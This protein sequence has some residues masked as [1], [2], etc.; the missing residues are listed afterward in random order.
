[1]LKRLLSR[2]HD[3][4]GSAVATAVVVLAITAGLGTA[5]YASMTTQQNESRVE[6]VRESSFNLAEGALNNQIFALTRQ[7]PGKGAGNTPPST[8]YYAPCTQGS[9]GAQCPDGAAM[10]N[11]FANVDTDPN[12]T[13]R[14]SVH[15]N[16]VQGGGHCGP[17]SSFYNDVTA[18][19]QPGYDRNCD[20]R[21]WVRAQA[22][23]RGKKRTL[24]ALVKVETQTE[25]LPRAAMLTGGATMTNAAG[26]K[27][28]VDANGSSNGQ[29][30]LV[31]V[32]CKRSSTCVDPKNDKN[33]PEDRF[34]PP[35]I[36]YDYP[37]AK[38]LSDDAIARLRAR[39]VADGTFFTTC[40]SLWSGA[41][42]WVETD[43]VCT[44]QDDANSMSAPGVLMMAR[45]E[46]ELR[47]NSKFYGVI[48]HLNQQGS[49]DDIVRTQG[50][51]QVFGGVIIDG[52]GRMDLGGSANDIVYEPTAFGGV[53]SYGTAGIIQNT[54]REIRGVN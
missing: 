32:R 52:G 14:T 6:R 44:I 24:V 3:D 21:V 2:V 48:Y 12:A 19:Q 30:G 51:S 42:V 18:Q 22:S 47:G 53:A 39:A 36:T 35:T 10:R 7:W 1:M 8:A 27:I 34:E 13:W 15:D 45:G 49:T 16:G 54:W 20:G 25:E 11:L 26:G 4:R 37:E 5:T 17:A 9:T 41:V 23:V 40:P 46:L 38:A 31:A 33:D 28:M 29:P 43:S 50:N